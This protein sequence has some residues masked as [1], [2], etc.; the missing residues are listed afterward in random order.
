ML[1]NR[2]S[3]N[4]RS[5][6]VFEAVARLRSIKDAATELGIT[7]S[8]VSHQL[9]NLSVRWHSQSGNIFAQDHALCSDRIFLRSTGLAVAREHEFAIARAAQQ[10]F[11]DLARRQDTMLLSHFMHSAT[12]A[13]AVRPRPDP[14][15][16][17]RSRHVLCSCASMSGAL[18]ARHRAWSAAAL[19]LVAEEPLSLAGSTTDHKPQPIMAEFGRTGF[20]QEPSE[21]DIRRC[22]AA[23]TDR[24]AESAMWPRSVLPPQLLHQ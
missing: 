21:A 17:P 14:R 6:Q 5:F 12:A 22:R 2:R 8:A 9:R 1:K 4:L 24:S 13:K 20:R 7:P 10:Q 3:L 16:R 15:T 19:R 23:T 18:R 11:S